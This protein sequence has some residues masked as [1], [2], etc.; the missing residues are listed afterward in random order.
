MTPAEAAAQKIGSA[1]WSEMG[2]VWTATLVV[3][4]LVAA[5]DFGGLASWPEG[6]GANEDVRNGNF[7]VCSRGH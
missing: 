6:W 7:C 5:L 1:Q 3:L 4:G 2:W